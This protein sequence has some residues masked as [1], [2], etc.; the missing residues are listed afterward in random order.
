MRRAIRTVALL[1]VVG[2]VAAACGGSSTPSSS[3]GSKIKIGMVYDLAGRGDHSFNDSA[4]EGLQKAGQDFSNI[5][6]KDLTPVATGSNREA[7]MRLL[8][9]QGYGLI[10]GNGFAFQDSCVKVAKD[11]PN[12]K[13]ACTDTGVPDLTPSS[14]LLNMDFAA[15][16]GSFLVGAA[17]ALKSKSGQI[18]FIGGVDVALIH[19]FQAGYEAGAKYINPNIKIDVKYLTTP[20]D[21][22]GFSDPAKGKEAAL[23][24][25]QGGDDVIYHAAGGSGDGLFAA[26]AEFSTGAGPGKVWAI[27]VDGDQ[28]GSAPADEQPYILTSMI[29]KVG[30]AV[31]DEIKDFLDGK[32]QG[33]TR[34]FNLADGGI[35][36]ATT[37]G[38]VDDIKAKL[39]DLKQKIISG[40]I[41]VPTGSS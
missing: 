13:F 14:N 3:G 32:F 4:Y 21:F 37:G 2:L 41:T 19:D 16:Q 8:A 35:D 30:T 34:V 25:Y 28:R 36:Y 18:G 40:E 38:D 15:N 20:P 9:Q 33:G 1:A 31:Y 6:V 5:A 17:A 11:Y 12:I 24:L 23:G 10:F 7:L 26:A 39:D 29:K 22:S 27:G